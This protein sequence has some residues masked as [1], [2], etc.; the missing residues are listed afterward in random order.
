LIA[1]FLCARIQPAL[2]FRRSRH[3]SFSVGR[4]R[5][6][7][8]FV[9]LPNLWRESQKL[10]VDVLHVLTHHYVPGH[11]VNVSTHLCIAQAPCS[12]WASMCACMCACMCPCVHACTGMSSAVPA[13]THTHTHT[14]T[15][16]HTHAVCTNFASSFTHT[17]KRVN[18]AGF[19]CVCVCVYIYCSLSLSACLY[20][21]S[22]CHLC[23]ASH[24][25][26]TQALCGRSGLCCR[27]LFVK[28]HL[29]CSV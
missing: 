18:R 3:G 19:V 24:G 5:A 11:A 1:G 6:F 20:Q 2:G 27:L 10:V 4:H 15:R 26:C 22:H 13:S 29:Q 12:M 8:S 9:Q 23:V 25:T 16:T 17:S 28:G 14:H 7:P 21:L